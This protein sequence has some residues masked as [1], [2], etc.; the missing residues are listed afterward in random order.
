MRRR[1]SEDRR[2]AGDDQDA[3]RWSQTWGEGEEERVA[4]WLSTKGRSTPAGGR[5]SW[6]P[7]GYDGERTPPPEA[8]APPAGGRESAPGRDVTSVL[9]AQV[10]DL[11]DERRRLAAALRHERSEAER[12]RREQL[13]ARSLLEA[14]IA[15][16]DD[17]RRHALASAEAARAEARRALQEEREARAAMDAAYVEARRAETR[18]F[19]VWAGLEVEVAAL[20]AQR[21][22][23][24]ALRRRHR[25]Y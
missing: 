24:R 22:R 21:R 17:E 9:E 16:L 12:V 1:N 19:D 8:S 25:R 11:E 14:E 15:G 6:S 18:H 7:S 4:R 2:P 23:L 3:S 13:A 10:A 20:K 5:D